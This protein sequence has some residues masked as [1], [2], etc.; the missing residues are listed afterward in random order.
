MSTGGVT[1]TEAK[2]VT[3]VLA[4]TAT[5]VTDYTVTAKTLTLAAGEASA[6]ATVTAVDDTAIDSG[7]SIK[8]TAMLD[9]AVIGVQQT[10]TIADNDGANTAPVFSPQSVTRQV[11]ENAAPGTAVGSPVTATDADL[12]TLTYTLG[13]ADAASFTIVAASG[14]IQTKTGVV[15]DHEAASNTYSVT[16]TADDNHGGTATAAVVIDI[17]DVNEPPEA[18]A[19]PAVT[20]VPDRARAW[21]CPGQRRTRRKSPT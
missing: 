18:P 20:G 16:V 17:A 12:H 2:T 11:A 9:G 6:N 7:E 4:G 21:T 19:T 1:F 8:V 15:Y 13:G 5:E 3:L 10:I 14:Q